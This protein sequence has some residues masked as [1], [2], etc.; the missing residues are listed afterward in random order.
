MKRILKY[1]FSLLTIIL[2][3]S[4][5][6]FAQPCKYGWN[7]RQEIKFNNPSS[8]LLSD[9]QVEFVLPTASLVSNSKAQANGSDVR[10]VD[11][12][13]NDLNFWIDDDTYNTSS[14][15]FWVKMDSLAP[16]GNTSIFIFYGKTGEI[17]NSNGSATFEMFDDFNGS[18]LSSKWSS[19]DSS[20]NNITISN[21]NLILGSSSGNNASIISDSIFS[22]SEPVRVEMDLE[23]I[24]NGKLFLGI[25]SSSTSSGLGMSYNAYGGTSLMELETSSSTNSALCKSTTPLA[26]FSALNVMGTWSYSKY[27]GDSSY[28]SWPGG[29]YH[30]IIMNLKTS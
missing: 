9:F 20:N 4:T 22:D 7:Y 10:I 24:S 5:V 30:E 12:N 3:S 19:C 14:T 15:S 28:L 29:I 27:A 21:G 26:N 13:G 23:A 11:F 8:T 2:I 6:A 18:I 1:Y 16:T 17:S 25:E